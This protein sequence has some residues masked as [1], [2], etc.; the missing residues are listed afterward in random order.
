MAHDFR[1]AIL[2]SEIARSDHPA[3]PI[4]TRGPR[5]MTAK[6]AIRQSIEHERHGDEQV[7]RRPR[8]RRVPPCGGRSAGMNHIAWQVGHLISSERKNDRGGQAR[9]VPAPARRV[10]R[11]GHGKA[12][13]RFQGRTRGTSS[14][15]AE[16]SRRLEGPARGDEGRPRIALRSRTRRPRPGSRSAR[17]SSRPSA[18][19]HEH[20]RRDPP[21]DAR[22]ASSSASGGRSRSRSRSD[23]GPTCRARHPRGDRRGNRGGRAPRSRPGRP[24]RPI[25]RPG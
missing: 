25:A 7:S 6:D 15:K 5:P 1:W 2:K 11:Q 4:P 3:S 23:R 16:L 13:D 17:L 24:G 20:V 21:D 12:D 10:R 8:R 22:S 18:M 19:P 9:I 14:T